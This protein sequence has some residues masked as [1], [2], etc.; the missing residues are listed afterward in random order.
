MPFIVPRWLE[1]SV[2]FV[3]VAAAVGRTTATL[4]KHSRDGGCALTLHIMHGKVYAATM[5][6]YIAY[7]ATLRQLKLATRNKCMVAAL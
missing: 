2:C 1:H 5:L 6:S 3:R 7:V 4:T